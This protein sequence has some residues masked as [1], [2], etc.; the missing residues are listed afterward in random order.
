MAAKKQ[1]KTKTIAQRIDPTY[2]RNWHWLRRSRFFLSLVLVALALVGA[3]IAYAQET[4][5]MNGPVSAAHKYFEADCAK[6]HE[7]SFSSV[8]DETCRSCH[9]ALG[10][11]VEDDADP[12]CGTCHSEHRGQAA[13]WDVKDAHCNAC[14]QDHAGI[15][16]FATHVEFKPE[17][18]KQHLKFNHDM[19][20]KADLQDGPLECASCHQGQPDGRDF[21]PVSFAEHC[22]K[23]HTDYLDPATLNEKVPHGLQPVAVKDWISAAYLR[24]MRT[25][26]EIREEATPAAPGAGAAALPSWLKVL[27]ERTAAEYGALFGKNGR[28]CLICHELDGNAIERPDVPTN[29]LA[30]ARF[31]HKTH[32][33]EKCASCHDMA[34]STTADE[35]RLPGVKSCAKCHAEDSGARASCVTCHGFH[36]HGNA[37]GGWK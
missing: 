21:K 17:P 19:H 12:A 25:K 23:C 16:S 28:S 30:K 36:T 31:D 20:L 4:P 22:A 33:I 32:R 5:F 37:A 26:G 2:F 9:H 11:H 34:G 29:W 7:E 18:R 24:A 35:L 1:K 8:N 3:A 27:E 14:H 10:Q 15:E 13:L 6:C